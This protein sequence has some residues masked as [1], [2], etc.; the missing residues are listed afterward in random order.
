MGVINHAQIG[1]I[2]PFVQKIRFVNF[3][4][5]E[6]RK[7]IVL[8]ELFFQRFIAKFVSALAWN[9]S[10]EKFYVTI[11]CGYFI[12]FNRFISRFISFRTYLICSYL[13]LSINSIQV[14]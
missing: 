9:A 11:L 2:G 12:F 5:R 8:F 1:Q 10:F 13:H 7:T 6:Q 14:V 3:F 4:F